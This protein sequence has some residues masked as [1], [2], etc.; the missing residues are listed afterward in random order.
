MTAQPDRSRPPISPKLRCADCAAA[1]D[2]DEGGVPCEPCAAEWAKYDQ[3]Y[4][5]LHDTLVRR[6]R[7]LIV[8]CE[9][10]C[11]AEDVVAEA[12]M[13]AMRDWH[14]IETNP[15]GWVAVVAR[16]LALKAPRGAPHGGLDD[17]RRQVTWSSQAPR[18]TPEDVDRARAAFKAIADLPPRQRLAVF[19]HH[20]E[21]W[22]QV[23]IAR[24][25]GRAPSTI[26]NSIRSGLETVRETID[27]HGLYLL[28]AVPLNDHQ[29]DIVSRTLLEIYRDDFALLAALIRSYARHH[30]LTDTHCDAEGVVQEAFIWALRGDSG[31]TMWDTRLRWAWCLLGARLHASSDDLRDRIRA[32]LVDHAMREIHRIPPAEITPLPAHELNMWDLIELIAGLDWYEILAVGTDQRRTEN[33]RT[34]ETLLAAMGEDISLRP[35]RWTLRRRRRCDLRSGAVVLDRN[36][37]AR[38]TLGF[39]AER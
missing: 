38:P 5:E 29:W 21:G 24:A 11:D 14:T 8:R 34:I 37:G 27:N 30:G 28:E 6:I 20:V 35:G 36:G 1:F 18:V 2:R 10:Q 9:L 15:R 12:L 19:L 16:R 33:E 39:A 25:E 31:E 7:S 22:S 13:E 26:A 4:R 17:E 3:L 32:K 23:E